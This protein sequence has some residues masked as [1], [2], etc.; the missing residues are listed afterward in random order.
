[1]SFRC[2]LLS[3]FRTSDA[4]V[5]KKHQMREYN[6]LEKRI[7]WLKIIRFCGFILFCISAIPSALVGGV[8]NDGDVPE[9]TVNAIKL[10]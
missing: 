3:L 8:M 2:N 1:M 6:F 9:Q 10:T 5:N 7:F 4:I